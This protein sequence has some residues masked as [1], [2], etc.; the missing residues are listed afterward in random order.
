M[1]G[2][3]CEGPQFKQTRWW[4]PLGTGIAL[5]GAVDLD[6]SLEVEYQEKHSN[7]YAEELRYD[8]ENLEPR[9]LGCVKGRVGWHDSKLAGFTGDQ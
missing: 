6:A 9:A 3:L 2:L 1:P 7:F 4:A 8:T 5:M